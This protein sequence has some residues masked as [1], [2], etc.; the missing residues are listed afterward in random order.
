M[1]EL[2]LCRALLAT[3]ERQLAEHAQRPVKSQ[4]V[5]IGALSGCEPDLLLTLF[6]HATA[7]SRFARAQLLVEFQPA[8]IECRSC[9]QT[10]EVSSNRFNCPVCNS[11]EVRLIAGESV[12]LTG[13][14]LGAEDVS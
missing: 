11:L 5:S 1:H 7:G 8:L 6:P 14:T 2:A 13:I 9:G 3:A 12:F 10:S 4:Q